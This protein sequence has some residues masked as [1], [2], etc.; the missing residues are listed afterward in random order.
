MA[1]AKFS[2]KVVA[3]PSVTTEICWAVA[4]ATANK[5]VKAARISLL[6]ML[7]LVYSVNKMNVISFNPQMYFF[8]YCH[9]NLPWKTVRESIAVNREGYF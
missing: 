2:Y 9:P 1:S 4:I 8:F 7:F 6:V 3:P 5:A